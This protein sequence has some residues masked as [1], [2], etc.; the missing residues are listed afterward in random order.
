MNSL[1]I[2]F[3]E[4]NGVFRYQYKKQLKSLGPSVLDIFTNF[5][6]AQI[7]IFN[8]V[9]A[10]KPYDI[11]VCDHNFYFFEEDAHP[12][13][14]GNSLYDEIRW[15]YEEACLIQPIFIHFSSEPCPEVYDA[16]DDKFFTSIRKSNID[17]AGFIQNGEFVTKILEER[18]LL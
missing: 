14:L 13:R 8:T 17:L 2:L 7:A 6:Q 18:G 11:V 10:K 1:K 4:D 9:K 3:I 5:K 12:A 16:K 15:R